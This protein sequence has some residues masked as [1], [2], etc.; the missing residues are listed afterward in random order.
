MYNIFKWAHRYIR[1]KINNILI[2][3]PMIFKQ[4]RE[5][6]TPYLSLKYNLKI[7]LLL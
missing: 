5:E 7:T 2:Q 6:S 1:K 4:Q 3:F